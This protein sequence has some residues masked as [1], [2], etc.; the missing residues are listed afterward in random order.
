MRKAL[1]S[2]CI[3]VPSCHCFHSLHQVPRAEC[4]VQ[5]LLSF[6]GHKPVEYK[7]GSKI[8]ATLV[9]FG[10]DI[11]N[12]QKAVTTLWL[13]LAM[14]RTFPW[15]WHFQ[16]SMSVYIK[17]LQY[18][19]SKQHYNFV[20]CSVSVFGSTGTCPIWSSHSFVWDSSIKTSGRWRDNTHLDICASQC[21]ARHT[22]VHQ[23]VARAGGQVAGQPPCPYCRQKISSQTLN[24]SLQKIITNILSL[25]Q[26]LEKVEVE[27]NEFCDG[28]LQAQTRSQILQ[29]ELQISNRTKQV[30][31]F[32]HSLF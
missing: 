32:D 6:T 13:L 23:K 5:N 4:Q 3:A 17:L 9:Q 15:W 22:S 11:C 24:I 27:K 29:N 20:K 19:W 18:C 1:A 10:P 2:S 12:K 7:K 30:S 16:E 21:V 26:K 25:H 31:S 28:F 8:Y 14:H